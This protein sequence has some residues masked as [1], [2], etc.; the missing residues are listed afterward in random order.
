MPR[1]S[2]IGMLSCV[3]GTVGSSSSALQSVTGFE[4]RDAMLSRASG[5]CKEPGD[6]TSPEER[7]FECRRAGVSTS[8]QRSCSAATT[9]AYVGGG[10]ASEVAQKYIADL[11]EKCRNS[12]CESL[13]TARPCQEGQLF[14]QHVIRVRLSKRRSGHPQSYLGAESRW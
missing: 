13:K 8:E 5:H 2:H 14:A 12:C 1:I 6:S 9:K 7:R 11:A 4:L 3:P 10:A